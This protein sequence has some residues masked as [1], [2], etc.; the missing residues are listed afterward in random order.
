MLALAQLLG[1]AAVGVL[2][3]SLG[4]AP[5]AALP[6]PTPEEATRA[7]EVLH[8]QR[9]RSHP[10]ALPPAAQGSLSAWAALQAGA[11]GF[12]VV[13]LR[14]QEGALEGAAQRVEL[15]LVALG[16]RVDLPGLLHGLFSQT[17]PLVLDSVAAEA[18]PGER[19]VRVTLQLHLFRVPQPDPERVEALARGRLPAAESEALGP[20]LE[21]A[22]GLLLAERFEATVPSLQAISERSRDRA[23]RALPGWLL[24]LPRRGPLSAQ[25]ALGD[26][27]EPPSP[28][29]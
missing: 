7:A 6:A 15:T 29:L 18:A 8:T 20:A 3:L 1:L 10:A 16:D 14:W 21:E 2:A 12:D 26:A 4:P 19:A 5:D 27:A 28:L 24:A 22:A 23:A 9:L 17:R 25:L 13:D 11:H